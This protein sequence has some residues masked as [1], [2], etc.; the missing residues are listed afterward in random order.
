[1]PSINTYISVLKNSALMTAIAFPELTHVA[2]SIAS[3]TFR[4]AEMILVL[5]ATYL[6]LVWSL[7]I[8]IRL[9]ESHLRLPE[10]AR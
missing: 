5:A 3:L 9:V 8:L 10:E 1:P 7:S 4:D 6:T 2:R